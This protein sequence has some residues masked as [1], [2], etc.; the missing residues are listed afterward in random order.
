MLK[1]ISWM[2][3]IKL[4][5]AM[6]LLYYLTVTVIIYRKKILSLFKTRFEFEGNDDAGAVTESS[7][8][9]PSGLP[10]ERE[11]EDSIPQGEPIERFVKDLRVLLESKTSGV[12]GSKQLV[13]EIRS[14]LSRFPS[15]HDLGLRD[16]LN[17]FILSECERF[18]VI[19]PDGDELGAIWKGAV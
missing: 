1:D 8:T 9:I 16:T 3:Y 7:G 14:V 11:F 12:H 10:A 5:S 13:E 17:E 6:T 2:E 19:I 4:V 15:L 18:Q